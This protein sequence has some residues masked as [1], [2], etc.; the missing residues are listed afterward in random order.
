MVTRRPLGASLPPEKRLVAYEA[1]LR[2][3]DG[4]I[5]HLTDAVEAY[6]HSRSPGEW[7]RVWSDVRRRVFGLEEI[8]HRP[9]RQPR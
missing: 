4:A 1:R 9:F 2:E 5:E 6:E 8:S 7:A 3:L